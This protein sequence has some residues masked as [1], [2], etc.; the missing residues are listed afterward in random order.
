ME[1]KQ[2]MPPREREQVEKGTAELEAFMAELI[3]GNQSE[4]KITWDDI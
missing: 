4:P 2:Y 1:I 3:S